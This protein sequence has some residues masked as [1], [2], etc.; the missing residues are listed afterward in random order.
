MLL[1]PSKR[2]TDLRG[3][4]CTAFSVCIRTPRYYYISLVHF[5]LIESI[6]NEKLSRLKNLSVTHASMLGSSVPYTVPSTDT[7][8]SV[9]NKI[10]SYP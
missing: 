2:V 6:G 8:V 4:N 9:K 3:K 7:V 10:V 1:D 5:N